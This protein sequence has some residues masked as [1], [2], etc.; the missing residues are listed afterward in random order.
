VLGPFDCCPYSPGRHNSTAWHSALTSESVFRKRQPKLYSF[1]DCRESRRLAI[2]LHQ[3]R[4]STK[5]G[6][7]SPGSPPFLPVD[8]CARCQSPY[9][10]DILCWSS[11]NLTDFV[12]DLPLRS[13]ELSTEPNGRH[14]AGYNQN[15]LYHIIH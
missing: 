12:Q 6:K 3:L 13:H 5:L 2:Q 11:L 8:S 9:S 10:A 15:T 7:E 1:F 14:W 4:Q